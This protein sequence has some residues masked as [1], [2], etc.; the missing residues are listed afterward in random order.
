MVPAKWAAHFRRIIDERN[1]LL[2]R[3]FC[4]PAPSAGKQDDLGDGATEET[5]RTL[6]FVAV[7]A[8]Q[9]TVFEVLQAIRRIERGTYGIPE[10][11]GESIEEA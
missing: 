4:S 10:V 7:G 3:N 6:A 11:I 9:E 8:T 1:R 5:R 2:A